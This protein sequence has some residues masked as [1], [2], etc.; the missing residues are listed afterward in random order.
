[1]VGLNVRMEVH[2]LA[3][4]GITEDSSHELALFPLPAG[5]PGP[6]PAR[7]GMYHLAWEMPSFEAL[8]Q[9]HRRLLA[10]GVQIGGYSEGQSNV[11]F[12]DPDG[13]ENEAFWEP[14][15]AV[16]AE[17]RAA[18]TPMPQLPH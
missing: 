4:L 11:M 7:V 14:A 6:E 12:L 17:M 18:G 16:L 3:F 15:P 13:N 9:L 1:V 8:E 10:N 2:G 5:A